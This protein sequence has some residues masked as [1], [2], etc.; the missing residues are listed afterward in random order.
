MTGH[1][2]IKHIAIAADWDD[3]RKGHKLA[4]ILRGKAMS[5]WDSLDVFQT[6]KEDWDGFKN[7]FLRPLTPNTL[8]K[9]FALTHKL[10]NSI[11]TYF[12][13]NSKTFKEFTSIKDDKITKTSPP[14]T[15]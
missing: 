6:N 8:P 5:W 13:R 11:F 14:T 7:S 4:S 12:F 3:K 15:T 2:L 1:R 10:N 9:L